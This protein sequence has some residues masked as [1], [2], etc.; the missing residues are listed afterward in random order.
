[1]YAPNLMKV[2]CNRGFILSRS[3]LYT[4]QYL[5]SNNFVETQ[6]KF[7][8]YK[9]VV[10]NKSFGFSTNS[11]PDKN[12]NVSLEKVQKKRRRIISNSSSDE[13]DIPSPSKT[14]DSVK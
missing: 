5:K 6:I 10:M 12:H 4:H 7:H 13:N 8:R 11:S 3:F 14:V 2:F 9:M 1:M